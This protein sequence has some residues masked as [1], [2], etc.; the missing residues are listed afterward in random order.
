MANPWEQIPLADYEAHM[1]LDSVRQLQALDAMMAVQLA[2]QDGKRVIV[3]GVAGG[4]GL[5]H[6]DPAKIRKIYGVDINPDYLEACRERFPALGEVFVPVLAD[7]RDPACQLPRAD[8]VIADLFVE[9]VGYQAFADAVEKTGAG[10]V[11]VG[12]Q[13]NQGDGFVSDS[14]YLHVF[15]RLEEVHV[16]MEEPPLTAALTEKGFHLTERQMTVLPNGKALERLEYRR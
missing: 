7:V 8:L 15:D 13:L 12:I 6:V 10:A 3:F 11:S 5:D 4:N 14:P 9:Y 1:A 16:Q 2:E